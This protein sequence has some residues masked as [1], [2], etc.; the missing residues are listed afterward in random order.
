MTKMPAV[1]LAFSAASSVVGHGRLLDLVEAVDVLG[2]LGFHPHLAGDRGA[3]VS[4]ADDQQRLI[5]D[6]GRDGSTMQL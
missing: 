2:D 1:S 3:A 5:P 4:A 6:H